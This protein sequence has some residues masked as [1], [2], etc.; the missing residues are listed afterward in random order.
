[1][2]RYVSELFSKYDKKNYCVNSICSEEPELFCER[3]SK[4]MPKLHFFF[5]K[6]YK[7]KVVVGPSNV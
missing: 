7:T 6:S 5:I 4:K 3:C 2:R 1:M